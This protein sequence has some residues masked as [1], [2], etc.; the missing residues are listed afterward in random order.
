MLDRREFLTSVGLAAG[1]ACGP[2]SLSAF[3]NFQS[4][5]VRGL[6]MGSLIGDAIGGPVEFLPPDR[7]KEWMPGARTWESERRLDKST[8]E[9]LAEQLSMQGYEVLR[10]ETAAY[11]PWTAR[12]PRGTITDDSRHKIICMRALKRMVAE[13]RDRLTQQ[14]LAREFLR[15]TP[16]E[17]Q[18]P[19]DELAKLIEEGL[20]E[21]RYA[22]R[23]ILGSRDHGVALPVE[24]LW[25]G[26]PNCSGQMA[27][28]PL[29]GLCPG[30]PNAAYLQTYHLNFLDAAIARDIVSA[31]NAALAVALDPS[32]GN[33]GQR[34]N[35]MRRA[36]RNTDP[37][38]MSE[39]PFAGR[40]LDRWLDLAESI[41]ERAEGRP[42]VVYRL[43]E[44]EGQPVYYWDAHFT[45]LV[46]WTMLLLCDFEPLSAMHLT[47]DFGHDTD[48]Y[49]QVLGAMA[50]AAH[51]MDILPKTMVEAVASRLA[52]D[53]GESVSDW[54]HTLRIASAAATE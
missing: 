19:N 4:D 9:M 42:A 30:D 54:A 35:A 21:Y 11:G 45:L 12:A 15:F 46:P 50:G 7:V 49:C 38:R 25:S 51:G 36:L 29:A 20:R 18:K 41:V 48:S 24:R 52:E 16:R 3:S 32:L 17:D 23:W 27:L 53:Y 43:L 26:I 44:Q 34:W 40:P 31:I 22:S 8:R 33:P 14:D 2:R 28:L 5:R 47:L 1:T 37:Y 10:P 39:V 13:G 6:L